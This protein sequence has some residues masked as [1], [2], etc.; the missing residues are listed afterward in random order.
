MHKHSAA[1][2]AC[3]AGRACK[4][5]DWIKEPDTQYKHEATRPSYKPLHCCCSQTSNQNLIRSC[6]GLSTWACVASTC[7][8][9]PPY[10]CCKRSTRSRSCFDWTLVQINAGSNPTVHKVQHPKLL[11]LLLQRKCFN[12]PNPQSYASQ[13][14]GAQA[15][16]KFITP[17]LPASPCN[18]N[19]NANLCAATAHSPMLSLCF[20]PCQCFT[21]SQCLKMCPGHY[22]GPGPKFAGTVVST[23]GALLE[24]AAAG[25]FFCGVKA[26]RNSSSTAA[27]AESDSSMQLMSTH[28]C[29][30]HMHAAADYPGS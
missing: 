21:L 26:S 5:R 27:G 14:P 8:H 16:Y 1:Q 4:S 30:A 23:H 13:E 6:P 29:F 12:C 15:L 11:Q 10:T 22:A 7:S 17:W 3:T 18:V 25:A 2:H 24:P 19:S 9:G 28:S 20:T